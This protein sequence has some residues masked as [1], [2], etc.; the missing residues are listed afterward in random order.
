MSATLQSQHIAGEEFL[1]LG[2]VI[3]V[4][5]QST[6]GAWYA[7]EGDHCSCPGFGFRGRCRHLVAAQQLRDQ[8]RAEA[9]HWEL[10]PA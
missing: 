1:N 4:K 9:P 6:P 10:L 5:S 7:I 2:T 8:A 3:L